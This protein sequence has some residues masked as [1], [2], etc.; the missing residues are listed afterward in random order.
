MSLKLVGYAGRILRVD[1]TR[2]QITEEI[3]SQQTVRD[4]IGGA[5]L[6]AKVLYDEVPPG[7]QWNDPRNRLVF[8]TGP[9]NG[10]RV[11]GAGAFGVVTKGPLT[12]GAASSQANGYFGA[13][14]RFSGYD[15]VIVQGTA[16]RWLYLYVHDGTAELRDAAFLVGKDTIENEELIKEELGKGERELSVFGIGPAG[17]NLVKFA[18]IV[19]DR[20]HV[21][22][23][24]GIGAVMGSK[25][26]KA[27]AAARG[28]GAIPVKDKERLDA[29]S[30]ETL[31][32]WKANPFS[33]Y[34]WGT[35]MIFSNFAIQ[36]HLGV[37]NLTS[38]TFPEHAN[39]MGE[40]YREKLGLK[41][42]ACWACP[43]AHCHIVTVKE[44]PYAGYVAEEPEFEG[45]E[46]WGS[47]IGQNDIGAAVM[48]ND[49]TDRLGLELNET[50]WTIA[51]SM[52]LFEKGTLK[53]KDTDGLAM[54]W[55]NVESV[56]NMLHN[57]A[58]R[59]GFGNV[60]AEGVMR[61]ARMIGEEAVQS[62]V[63]IEKGHAPKPHDSRASW[64]TTLDQATSSIGT[65]ETGTLSIP[66]PFSPE[67]VPV[68][69]AREKGARFFIDCLVVCQ[70][71]TLTKHS[72][73]VGHLVDMVNAATGRSLS[74]EEANTAG[75]RTANLF[76][77]FNVRH[78]IGPE[79]ETLS[80]RYFSSPAEGP[81]KGKGIA[82]YWEGML[83]TYY[84][85]MGW[86]RKTGK[87]LPDTLKKLGLKAVIPD[88]WPAG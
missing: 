81:K 73:F 44:G 58:H 42:S 30:R 60:L 64:A 18:A 36:G 47:L 25:K 4:F 19:G 23:H 40:N 45:W 55:G 27:V 52:E 12:N 72:T 16:R 21:A 66:N 24:N 10:L 75:V 67:E 31:E 8:A 88:L 32:K 82:P 56:R 54:N 76:R 80:P 1:L 38:N 50:A 37:K 77:A 74:L 15:A 69:V 7:V 51:M 20:G 14:L 3:L 57:I 39:F 33:H 59:R 26:L 87:P 9:L 62:A 29:V 63:F 78:G 84:K 79:V 35:S 6:G 17:E 48:L 49:V 5:G 22:G 71:A 68:I 85:E 83:D 65:Y 53:E 46:A 86:D 43:A 61:A 41:R 34:Y 28:R 2:E 13:Y 11:A 70:F